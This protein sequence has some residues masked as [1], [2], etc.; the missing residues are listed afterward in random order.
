LLAWSEGSL[1]EL[2][3]LLTTAAV[4]AVTSGAER[5]DAQVLAAIAW[6]LPSERRRQAERLV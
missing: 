1:G 4:Y 5:I 6:V 2:S 3:A